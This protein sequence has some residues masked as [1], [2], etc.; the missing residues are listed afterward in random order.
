MRGSTYVRRL[1]VACVVLFTALALIACSGDENPVA[2]VYV[3]E[4]EGEFELRAD[5]TFEIRQPGGN[6]AAGTY[7]T[8]GDQITFVITEFFDETG[9]REPAP[10]GGQPLQGQIEGDTLIDPDGKRFVKR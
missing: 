1:G 10:E 3:N 4:V 5:G 7:T 2:G 6:G 9:Q 8:E